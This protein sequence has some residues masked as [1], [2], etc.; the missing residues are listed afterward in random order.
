MWRRLSQGLL[1]PCAALLLDSFSS[2]GLLGLCATLLLF[3]VIPPPPSP[4]LLPQERGLVR[5]QQENFLFL[6]LEMTETDQCGWLQNYIPEKHSKMR[7][8]M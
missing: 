8:F 3:V 7:L 6:I 1:G 2:Q 5:P 4:N